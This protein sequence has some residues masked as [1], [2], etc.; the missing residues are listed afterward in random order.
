VAGLP[1]LHP[2][3]QALFQTLVL[4]CLQPAGFANKDLR[5]RLAHLL[6]LD[7]SMIRPGQMTYHLRRL[8]L[9]GLITRVPHTHRYE[10]TPQGLRL[11][12]FCTRLQARVLQSGITAILPEAATTDPI[13][14]PA[15]DRLDTAIQ[16]FLEHARLV[17]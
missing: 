8:R 12:L 5:P 13:L 6:G 17:A 10:V 16:H 14:R 3:V 7:P 4:F 9:H 2:T 11:A 1:I 15:F